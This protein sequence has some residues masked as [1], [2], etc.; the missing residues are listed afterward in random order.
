[1]L[2][3]TS[4]AALGALHFY[5][6]VG[7]RSSEDGEQLRQ[8]FARGRRG[9]VAGQFLRSMA[10]TANPVKGD[11][12]SEY[13]NQHHASNHCE[14]MLQLPGICA[15]SFSLDINE[16]TPMARSCKY[17]LFDTGPDYASR[18]LKRV[19]RSPY[20][21]LLTQS[22]LVLRVRLKSTL[23]GT[24]ITPRGDSRVLKQ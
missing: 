8:L 22:L 7:E 23:T 3:S 24:S 15:D 13:S 21:Y 12:A 14:D 20:A 18:I 2:T 4:L 1:M 11:S 9:Y 5:A 6:A 17:L 16:H 19:E 10:H